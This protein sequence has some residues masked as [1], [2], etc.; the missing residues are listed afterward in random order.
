[1]RGRRRPLTPQHRREG[2][3]HGHVSLLRFDGDRTK[4]PLSCVY[5]EIRVFFVYTCI[6]QSRRLNFVCIDG[7]TD[8]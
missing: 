3:C 7:V 2:A 6:L 4:A 1:M 8:E 5:C